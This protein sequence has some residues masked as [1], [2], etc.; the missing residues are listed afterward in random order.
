MEQHT[1]ILSSA[2]PT[3]ILSSVKMVFLLVS[4][5]NFLFHKISF[6]FS[7]EEKCVFDIFATNIFMNCN[8]YSEPT[9]HQGFFEM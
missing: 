5:E 8:S 9:N 2:K 1:F 4:G 6:A 7:E 3:K